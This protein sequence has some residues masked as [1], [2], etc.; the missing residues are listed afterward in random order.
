MVLT[1]FFATM[2]SAILC[3]SNDSVFT[4]FTV[5][6]SILE[7]MLRELSK[8]NKI[9]LY[10]GHSLRRAYGESQLT[11][12]TLVFE[13]YLTTNFL[14]T[15]IPLMFMDFLLHEKSGKTY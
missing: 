13:L 3:I 15:T 9:D 10:A 4:F 2:G 12:K 5:P 7:L 8:N 14:F 11:Q 6:S 1:F